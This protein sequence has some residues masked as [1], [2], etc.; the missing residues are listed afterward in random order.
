MKKRTIFHIFEIQSPCEFLLLLLLPKTDGTIF[1][2][3]SLVP[4]ESASRLA[5]AFVFSL[6]SLFF[7]F[8]VS[9][10]FFFCVASYSYSHS[11]SSSSVPCIYS[12]HAPCTSSSSSSFVP[13]SAIFLRAYTDTGIVFIT[14][15]RAHAMCHSKHV[16]TCTLFTF[17]HT[18]K[19]QRQLIDSAVRAS[20]RRAPLPRQPRHT[21]DGRTNNERRWKRYS[22]NAGGCGRRLQQ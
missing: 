21:T 15:T 16:D 2:Q 20:R 10:F 5:S 22:S 1:R 18:D 8:A 13:Q 12:L 6:F 4:L 11:C 9:V 14:P 19:G 17:E 3:R 7:F